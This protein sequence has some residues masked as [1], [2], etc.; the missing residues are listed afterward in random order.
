MDIEEI[1]LIFLWIIFVLLVIAFFVYRDSIREDRRIFF[2]VIVVIS[3]ISI[4]TL[5]VLIYTDSIEYLNI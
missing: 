3:L 5:S 2:I 4:I 1:A